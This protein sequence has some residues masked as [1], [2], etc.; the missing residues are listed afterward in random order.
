MVCLDGHVVGLIFVSQAV[1]YLRIFNW[2][3][4]L[5]VKKSFLFFF[6]FFFP[7]PGN[8]ELSLSPLNSAYNLTSSLSSTASYA[9]E[10]SQLLVVIFC[11]TV[12]LPKSQVH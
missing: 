6:F 7:S 10:S 8:S 9:A 1:W 5:T 3:Q 2:L 12:S 4:S 11:L